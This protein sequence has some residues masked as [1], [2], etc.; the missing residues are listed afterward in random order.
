MEHF[1]F[2]S[3]PLSYIPYFSDKYEV[4]L[5]VKRDDLFN[6]ALGGSKSR[7]LQYILYPL[8]KNGIKTIVTAGGPCSNFNRAIALLCAEYGLKLKLVSYT[9]NIDEYRTSLNN[10]IVGLTDCEYFFC[11]K[12]EVAQTI[13]KVV[14]E[15]GD[16]THYLYG[17]GKSVYGIYAYYDAIKE[18]KDQI[19]NIDY[20]FV[21]CGTGTTLTG[22]C[23]G[24]QSLYPNAIIHGI[25]VARS[26]DDER[27]VLEE[28]MAILN[29]YLNN[30]YIS[31]H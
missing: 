5:Y 15:S 2:L 27:N 6:S 28:N 11:K 12:T 31:V 30:K 4:N 9:D 22:I 21:A 18:L 14:A 24:M 20:V 10:Y 13:E 1:D 26:F 3:T 23:A 8:I 16:L 17:G 7:M 19:P 29:S 25:S